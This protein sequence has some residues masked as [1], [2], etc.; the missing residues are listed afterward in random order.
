MPG[1]RL[2]LR[3]I[4]ARYRLRSAPRGVFWKR[5]ARSMV[6]QRPT[7]ARRRRA[8]TMHVP[9]AR[10]S[11]IAHSYKYFFQISGARHTLETI[12]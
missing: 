1:H 12:F 11:T 8:K 6:R 7:A 2:L 10:L 4:A 5:S 9:L 3:L